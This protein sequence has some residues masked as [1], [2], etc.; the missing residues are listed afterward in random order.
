MKINYG[1]VK[2]YK[3]TND[4][5]DKFYIVSTTKKHLSDRMWLHASS[6]M[7]PKVSN[8]KSMPSLPTFPSFGTVQLQHRTS[9]GFS[10]Q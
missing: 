9:G 3:I 7:D 1:R 8:Y 10:V 4:I 2:I 5:D 6:S